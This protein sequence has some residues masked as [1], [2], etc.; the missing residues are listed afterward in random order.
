MFGLGGI[1]VEALEDV[2]FG[3]TP[4]SKEEAKMIEG[5][6]AVK[7]LKGF[8]NYP[9]VNLEKAA[10]LLVNLSN[11]VENEEVEEVDF[12]PV[13]AKG[14]KFKIA[15]PK[16]YF[17]NLNS[18]FDPNSVAVI[19]AT[20]EEQSVG[21]K[22]CQNLMESDR[23][24]FFVNPDK[25]EVLGEE[26]YSS[27]KEIDEQIDLVVIAVPAEVVPKVVEEIP[28]STEGVIIISAGFRK[29]VKRVSRDRKELKKSLNKGVF[30][31]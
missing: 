9:S 6:R 13:F 12:N 4:V 30:L 29:A 11:L 14:D 5:I 18:F 7:V 20:D 8:R 23:T 21:L 27:V 17:M 2:S 1:F 24:L 26:T 16:D 15:D 22:L 25:D 31:C 10:N 3:I 19:G 28:D